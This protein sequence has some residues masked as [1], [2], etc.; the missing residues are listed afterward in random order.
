MKRPVIPKDFDCTGIKHVYRYDTE[1]SRSY[2][3]DV[4]PD[5]SETFSHW[6]PPTFSKEIERR[7]PGKKYRV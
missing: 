7:F 4:Q 3:T 1:M 6:E 5:G 2:L